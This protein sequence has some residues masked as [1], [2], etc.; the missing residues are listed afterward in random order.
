MTTP[1]CAPVA[2]AG[3]RTKP[4]TAINCPGLQQPFCL[5]LL[6][7]PIQT[8]MVI[9]TSVQQLSALALTLRGVSSRLRSHRRKTILPWLPLVSAA[10]FQ[11]ILSLQTVR[12]AVLTV[13]LFW[14]RGPACPSKYYEKVSDSETSR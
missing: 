13:M 6:T 3:R 5:L 9:W 14:L 7:L 4:Q 8:Q 11:T 10:Q 2:G 1:P 12:A